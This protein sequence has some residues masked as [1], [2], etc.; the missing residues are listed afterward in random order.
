MDN[1]PNPQPIMPPSGQTYYDPNQ[2]FN[3]NT[4]PQ[5]EKFYRKTWFVVLLMILFPPIGIVLAWVF[6]KPTNQVA[7]IVLTV[8]AVLITIGAVAGG[9]SGETT[10]NSTSTSDQ[11][12]ATESAAQEN[13]A[14]V[15]APEPEPVVE[16]PT[17]ESITAQYLGDTEEGATVT[18]EDV[19]VT[20]TYSDGTKE[21]VTDFTLDD[22]PTLEAGQVVTVVVTAEDCTYEMSVACTTPLKED[23]VATCES[24][25]YDSLAR[26]ESDWVGMNVTVTGKVIQVMEDS[27]GN[28]YRIDI[29]DEGNGFWD[30]TVLVAIDAAKLEDRIL[31]DDVVTVYG[32]STGLYT[33]ETV[34]GSTMTVPSIMAEFI[35]FEYHI[36]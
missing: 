29:T 6:K 1:I 8:L 30:D 36:D 19:T 2:N 10:E 33:Y 32:T 27:S 26:N 20:G 12:A 14:E 9:G 13:K 21:E 15:E 4:S 7:R 11:P 16:E 25:D 35:D 18:A 24:V 22:E 5:K 17:L 34:M 28:L 23:Y 31:E 3:Y